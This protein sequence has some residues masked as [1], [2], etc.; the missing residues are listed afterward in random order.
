MLLTAPPVNR[1]GSRLLSIAGSRPDGIVTATML[2]R[3]FGKSSEWIE[4]RTGIQ[5]L[6]RLHGGQSIGELALAAGSRAIERSGAEIDFVLTASCST[7][8]GTPHNAHVAEQLA[9]GRPHVEINIACSG[10]TYALAAAD[11]MIRTGQARHVLVVAAE[12]MSRYLDPADLGTSIIFGDGAGA[13]VVGP[14]P[15]GRSGIGPVVWGSDGKH[16]ALIACDQAP[17]GPMRMQGQSV[18]RWAVDTVPRIA[19]EACRRAGIRPADIDVFVPH[20]ANL[21]II[22]AIVRKLGIERATTATDVTTTG[23]T[24]AASIPIALSALVERGT[25]RAGQ[26]ALLVGFGA[27][28]AYAAQVITVPGA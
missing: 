14:A 2:G 1:C 18:F 4:Q 6:R 24:S 10:F 27:G 17:P 26:L 3:P 21:R 16:H 15:E 19:A 5:E 8:P 20:Q 9:P 13:A 28:L 22:D 12:H 7:E 25:A 11:A 23:N